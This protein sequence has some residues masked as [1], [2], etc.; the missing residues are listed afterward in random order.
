MAVLVL[1]VMAYLGCGGVNVKIMFLLKLVS[2]L[3]YA[4]EG[5]RH[6]HIFFNSAWSF[7]MESDLL[8]ARDDGD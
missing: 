2:T 7:A 6:A 1:A 5:R 4:I 8:S 3:N